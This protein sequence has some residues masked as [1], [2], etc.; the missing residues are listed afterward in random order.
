MLQEALPTAV[1]LTPE[2]ASESFK[3]GLL[4]HRFLKHTQTHTDFWDEAW[5]FAFL[6]SSQ[7]ILMLLGQGPNCENHWLDYADNWMVHHSI[8]VI[9]KLCCKSPL[10][11][12]P[13]VLL[14]SSPKH[15]VFS[16][17]PF[18]LSH[19]IPSQHHLIPTTLM[20]ATRLSS[21]ISCLFCCGG[22]KLILD[23]VI[24]SQS[25]L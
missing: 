3:R 9:W 21:I 18:H 13:F 19:F 8:N 11:A 5:E 2:W 25:K 6:T 24:F 4:T 10:S 17:T 14:L 20:V 15:M 23:I 7:V 1:V 12:I 16:F 22:C